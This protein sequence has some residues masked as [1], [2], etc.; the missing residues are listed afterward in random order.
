VLGAGEAIELPKRLLQNL[1]VN[2][3]QRIQCLVL[4]ARRYLAP[5]RKVLQKRDHTVRAHRSR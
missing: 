2:E 1:L 3:H 4:G 5:Q